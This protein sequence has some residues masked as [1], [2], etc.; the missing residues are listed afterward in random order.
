M[1]R[2]SDPMPEGDASAVVDRVGR[3]ERQA[4]AARGIA[5]H[6]RIAAHL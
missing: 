5:S 4:N 3:G 6:R 2:A 1:E